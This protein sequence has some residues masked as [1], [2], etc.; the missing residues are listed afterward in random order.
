[1]PVT[2]KDIAARLNLAKSTV[3]YALNGGPKSV[4]P[5]V[6]ARVLEAAK[7]MGFRPNPIA[8][9]LANGRTR[10]VG[11]VPYQLGS[12]SMYVRFA[13]VA[14]QTIYRAAHEREMHVL[15]PSGYDPER[16]VETREH[17]FRA[18]V[19]G[20]IMLMVD[21][22]QVLRDVKAC[23]VPLAMIASEAGDFAPTF[24]ADNYGGA[25]LA[26]QHLYQLGHRKIAVFADSR[27]FDTKE[28]LR[29]FRD[30]VNAYGLELAPEWVIE[31]GTS[32]DQGYDHAQRLFALD[33]QPTA[34]VCVNDYSA[35]GLMRAAYER[36]IRIP[37]DLSVIGF[38][39][40][41]ISRASM[42]PLTTIRQPIEDMAL[43]A[44]ASVLDQIDGKDVS[45]VVLPTTLV[46]RATT[47]PPKR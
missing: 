36:G 27:R 40:D 22:G 24:N 23:D 15:L 25:T 43:A 31:T 42:I 12:T 32:F 6:R 2:I 1:M 45:S 8:K 29:A 34:V 28:R 19:D 26:V 47:A 38:D 41:G 21:Q 17:L 11:F 14:L 46:V 37:H 9:S 18:P 5:G 3:S 7:E 30:T 13:Q 20:V 35:C 4:S 39:D 10:T 33:R 44:F 16:P